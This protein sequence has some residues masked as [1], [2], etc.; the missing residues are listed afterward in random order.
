MNQIFNLLSGATTT[1]A[2]LISSEK[3]THRM[4]SGALHVLEMKDGR[5]LMMCF[6]EFEKYKFNWEVSARV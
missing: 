1:L 4:S 2:S 3:W 6:A 5:W